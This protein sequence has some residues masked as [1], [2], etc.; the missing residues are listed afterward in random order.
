[1]PL[2]IPAATARS[3]CSGPMSTSPTATSASW[4]S[5][6]PPPSGPSDLIPSW[7]LYG[8]HGT[9]KSTLARIVRRLIDPQATAPGPAR[10][11]RDLMVSAVNGWLLAYDN[12]SVLPQWLS[13]GLCMLSTGGALAGNASFA[14]RRADRDPRPAPVILLTGW[15]S[16]SSGSTSPTAASSSTCRRSTPSNRRCEIEFWA[17]VPAR[18][19]ANPGWVCSTRS[20]AACTSC[21]RS[22]YGSCPAWPTSPHSPKRSAERSAGLPRRRCQTTTIIAAMRACPQIDDSPLAD[23]LLDLSPD[24]FIDWSGPVRALRRAHPAGGRLCRVAPVA[25][26]ARAASPSSSPHRAQLAVHGILVNFTRSRRGRVVSVARVRSV[27]PK[28]ELTLREKARERRIIAKC[29]TFQRNPAG[30]QSRPAEPGQQPGS[31]SCV[32]VGDRHCEA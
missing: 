19:S 23:F 7:P 22:S 11:M 24:Y 16:L 30:N 10:N 26:I 4:L 17:V 25:Q 12:V 5:G 6:W 13:D 15:R 1:M 18:L 27:L 8:Q 32:G 21:R 29:E 9:T 28:E 31:E 14:D 3:T 20:P 2:P